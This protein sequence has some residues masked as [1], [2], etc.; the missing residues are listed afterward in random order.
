MR[1]LPQDLE[2]YTHPIRR[3]TMHRLPQFHDRYKGERCFIIGNGPSLNHTDLAKLK[4]EYTFGMNR[5]FLMFEEL[6]FSTTFFVSMNDLVIEQSVDDIQKLE[7]PKF[8]NWRARQWLQPQDDLYFLYATYAGPKFSKNATRRLWEGAT[9]TYVSLQLAYYFGFS[10][11][12]LIGVDHSF[13]TKGEPNTTITS[14]GDDPNHF[15]PKY[16]GKGFRWQL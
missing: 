9:V 3:D 7:I 8:V 16:F 12:I 13:A 4:G 10:K 14:Q 2:A 5:I 1:R 6:G 11:V 15:H